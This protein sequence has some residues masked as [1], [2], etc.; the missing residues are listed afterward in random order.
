VAANTGPSVETCFYCEP[1]RRRVE[2]LV[3]GLRRGGRVFIRH[4]H[5]ECACPLGSHGYSASRISVSPGFSPS[6]CWIYVG[7]NIQA[8][9]RLETFYD[10]A[11]SQLCLLDVATP[12]ATS[13]ATPP[14]T[15]P[16]V[17][18]RTWA[19][20]PRPGQALRPHLGP[21]KRTV[22]PVIEVGWLPGC[23]FWI[24]RTRARRRA[25]CS[26]ARLELVTQLGLGLGW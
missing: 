13:P 12:P 18:T 10:Q 9:R 8:P 22:L 19:V 11:H 1:Q 21:E 2:S 15:S 14:T 24:K 26:N 17:W 7:S 23:L 5:G 16:R 3:P 25:E 4:R 6:V 20:A